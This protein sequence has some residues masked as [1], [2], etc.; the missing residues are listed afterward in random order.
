[1]HRNDNQEQDVAPIRLPAILPLMG[2]KKPT[3]VL[4]QVG[5]KE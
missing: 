1:M 3:R 4:P 5:Q 2:I